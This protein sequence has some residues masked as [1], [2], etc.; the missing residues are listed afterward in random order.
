MGDNRGGG[1]SGHDFF[2]RR[3]LRQIIGAAWEAAILANYLL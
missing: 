1:C 3:L 2:A